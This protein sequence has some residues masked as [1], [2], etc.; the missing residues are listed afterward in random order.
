MPFGH[1]LFIFLSLKL[2]A[3]NMNVNNSSIK[4]YKTILKYIEFSVK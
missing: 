3:K 4:Y 1:F 2:A